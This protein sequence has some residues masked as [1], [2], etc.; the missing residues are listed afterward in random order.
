MVLGMKKKIGSKRCV[1]KINEEMIEFER[2]EWP[3]IINQ[4]NV[5]QSTLF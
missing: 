5:I 1:Q 4:S 2:E 3:E